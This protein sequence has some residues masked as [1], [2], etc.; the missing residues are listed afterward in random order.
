MLRRSDIAEKIRTGHC[1]YG[2]PYCRGYVVIARSDIRRKRP[3]DVERGAVAET[4]LESD[5]G[6]DLVDGNV[7]GAFDYHLDVP[8][9]GAEG[10]LPE[11]DEFLDL[12]KVRC[13]RYTPGPQT[14][15]QAECDV[16]FLCNV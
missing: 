13:V 5:V 12:S 15:S 2:A 10:E 16:V 7:A 1:G 4:F 14:V 6:L 11:G 9:P 3:E 8:V